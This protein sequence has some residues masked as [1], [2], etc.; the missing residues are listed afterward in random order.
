[1]TAAPGRNPASRHRS[2]DPS[3]CPARSSTPP[4]RAR[5]GNTC[6]GRLKSPGLESSLINNLIVVARSAAETPVVIP[7]RG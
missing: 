1:M 3:V 5:N 2:T 7:C 4:G 6:P